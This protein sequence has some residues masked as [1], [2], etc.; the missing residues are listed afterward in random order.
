MAIYTVLVIEDNAT[1]ML[2]LEK[3]LASRAFAVLKAE[4][5]EEG[6][7]LATSKRPDLILMDI[8]LPGMDGFD[9]LTELHKDKSLAKIPVV[10]VTADMSKSL[11][12]YIEAGFVDLVHKPITLTK[13]IVALKRFGI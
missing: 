2:V 12:T 10:A 11:K 9:A 3:I 4:S 1:N 8:N 6:L 13:L 5:A 7:S